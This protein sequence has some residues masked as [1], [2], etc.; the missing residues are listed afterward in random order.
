[1]HVLIGYECNRAGIN[2]KN[3]LDYLLVYMQNLPLI[4][5]SYLTSNYNDSIFRDIPYDNFNK[6]KDEK[7]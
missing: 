7:I 3:C 5:S 1:M 4:P 2:G 6:L